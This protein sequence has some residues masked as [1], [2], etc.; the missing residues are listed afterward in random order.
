MVVCDFYVCSGTQRQGLILVKYLP[1]MRAVLDFHEFHGIIKHKKN[2][3][4]HSND[5]QAS[6]NSDIPQSFLPKIIILKSKS[7]A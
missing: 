5:N 3:E 4:I 7:I 1:Q 6:R 2:Y